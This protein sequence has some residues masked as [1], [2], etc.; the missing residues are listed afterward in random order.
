MKLKG[1]ILAI[2]CL[3]VLAAAGAVYAQDAGKPADS[4][5][6]KV[7]RVHEV[8]AGEDLHLIAGY[9][10]GDSRQ[11]K[12]IWE[13]NKREVRNPNR[14]SVG[15]TLNIEV[16]PGWKP[17]FSMDEYLNQRGAPR[18]T[19]GGVKVPIKQTK[20]VYEKE[21]VHSSVAPKLLDES[22]SDNQTPPPAESGPGGGNQESP[23][24]TVK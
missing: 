13:M 20:Y 11:W 15:Q 22:G 4:A 14:I 3:F 8:K 16:E 12:K 2:A 7:M 23:P 18:T 9:Y 24:Q 19:A 10:Y 6:Q 21:D 1:I 5:P 17:K